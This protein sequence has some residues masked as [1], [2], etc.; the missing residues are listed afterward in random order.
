[1]EEKRIQGNS[2]WLDTYTLDPKLKAEPYCEVEG[3]EES[4]TYYMYYR[5]CAN[6]F[7]GC[8]GH[9][10]VALRH[11]VNMTRQHTWARC[12]YCGTQMVAMN[13]MTRPFPLNVDKPE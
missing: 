7:M 10:H 5:C 11:L 1:M 13:Y 8:E 6:V 3:C 9:C 2:D 4:A 12:G